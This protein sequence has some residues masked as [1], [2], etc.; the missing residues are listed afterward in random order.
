M[1]KIVILFFSVALLAFVAQAKERNGGPYLGLN[2]GVSNYN[3]DGFYN[4]VQEKKIGTYSV[5]GGAYINRNLSVEL[6][7]MRS[8]DF[9]ILD[10]ATN[11]KSFNYSAVSVSAL[12]HYPL[13]DDAWDIFAK[14]GAGQSYTTMASSDGS[15]LVVGGGVSYRIDAMFALKMAY[16]RM[17][18]TYASDTRGKFNM[19]LQYAYAG[20][21]VQF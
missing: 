10:T 17:M 2:Y 4:Q 6:G 9:K 8:G 3:D 14:F 5:C 12:A 18:F 15:A 11:K 19:D 21:E 13:Y 20:I 16:D 7:Y 1:V